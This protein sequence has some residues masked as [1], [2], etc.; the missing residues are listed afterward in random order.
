MNGDVTTLRLALHRSGYAP[1]PVH[2]K[3]PPLKD[4]SQKID[5][6]PDEIALWGSFTVARITL[7]ALPG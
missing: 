2:G 5:A 7:V 3:A 1:I 6:T 4:W